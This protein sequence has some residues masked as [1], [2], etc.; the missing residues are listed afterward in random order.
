MWPNPKETANL[1]AYSMKL[2]TLMHILK[3]SL[4][5]KFFK[6][7]VLKIFAIFTGKHL[8]WRL[9]FDKVHTSMR[10]TQVF[11]S[12]YWDIFKNTYFKEHLRTAASVLYLELIRAY[13][14]N[15]SFC[16]KKIFLTS[17]AARYAFTRKR[18]LLKCLHFDINI[19][20]S[21]AKRIK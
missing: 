7:G 14:Q 18:F 20:R 21:T 17:V 4:M 1:V 19:F 13:L 6:I 9:F 16:M 15:I 8:C 2:L 3:K 5:K 12:E 11:S 10:P